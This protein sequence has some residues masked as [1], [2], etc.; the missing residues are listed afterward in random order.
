MREHQ[1]NN[2]FKLFNSHLSGSR[3]NFIISYNFLL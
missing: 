2:Y 1:E 3:Y